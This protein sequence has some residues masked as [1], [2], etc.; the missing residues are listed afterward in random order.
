MFV[1]DY[2]VEYACD[3]PAHPYYR[4]RLSSRVAPGRVERHQRNEA[5]SRHADSDWY[6]VAAGFH[7]DDRVSVYLRLRL[8][9]GVFRGRDGASAD[10][11]GSS[12]HADGWKLYTGGAVNPHDAVACSFYPSTA[13]RPAG[14][15]V[16]IGAGCVYL[17]SHVRHRE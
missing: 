4:A 14:R 13:S 10:V 12:R 15:T 16:Y 6:I 3:W 9:G 1:A 2:V 7:C 8:G 5:A 11:S 17:P